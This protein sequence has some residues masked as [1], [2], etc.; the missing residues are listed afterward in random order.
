MSQTVQGMNSNSSG[1]MHKTEQTSNYNVQT[2]D[3]TD[4][5]KDFTMQTDRLSLLKQNINISSGFKPFPSLSLLMVEKL[6]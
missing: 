4:H 3:C 6:G 2:I 5:R 1:V